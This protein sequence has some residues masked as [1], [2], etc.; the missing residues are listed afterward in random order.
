MIK[1]FFNFTF[2]SSDFPVSIEKFAAY[3]DGNLSDDEMQR[4]S[5]VIEKN[6][7]MQDIMDSMEQSELTLAK[8]RKENIKFPE[9]DISE[10]YFDIPNIDNH[11]FDGGLFEPCVAAAACFVNPI[12]FGSAFMMNDD[13]ISTCYDDSSEDTCN[14]ANNENEIPSDNNK[15]KLLNK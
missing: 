9:D 5:S 7:T 2:D 10:K 3:I 4:V 8:Y 11:L 13:D 6:D 12:M 15:D 14:S 1:D